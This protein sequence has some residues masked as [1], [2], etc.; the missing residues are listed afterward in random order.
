MLILT[1][2]PGESLHLG[3]DIKIT[4]LSLHGKQVKIG[5]TVPGDMTVYREEVYLRVTE[6][7]RRALEAST[8]DLMAVTQ[9]WQK[10]K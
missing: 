1:R 5:L 7:N 3:D 6:E 4:I 8:A 2:R 9:L 10:K